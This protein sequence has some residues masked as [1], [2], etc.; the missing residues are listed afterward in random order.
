MKNKKVQ[1]LSLLLFW[2]GVLITSTFA[3]EMRKIFNFS[4]REVNFR[5]ESDYDV[6]M[7][8]GCLLSDEIGK[9]QLPIKPVNFLIPS[10][11]K[12]ED[13]A[14]FAQ[15]IELS[16]EHNILPAQIP[17]IIGQEWQWTEPN[18]EIYTSSN[19]YPQRIVELTNESYLAG[20]KIASILIHPLQ[21]K[22]REKKLILNTEII[23]TLQY[24]QAT[25]TSVCPLR[26]LPETEKIFK[27]MIESIVVNPNDIARFSPRVE[28]VEPSIPQKFAPTEGPSPTSSVV[29]YVIITS[30]ELANTFQN[31]ADWKT[32]KGVPAVVRTLS[33]IRSR[34]DG[35]DD[36]ERIRN[37]IKDAYENWG[38]AWVLIGG[39][40]NVIPYREASMRFYYHDMLRVSTDLYYACLDGNWN[41]DGDDKFGE[42]EDS[43]DLYPEVFVGRASAENIQ[44]AEIFVAKILNYEKRTANTTTDYLTKALFIGEDLFERVTAKDFAIR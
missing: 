5:R 30:D 4:E 31:L 25:N 18:P 19:P 16:G 39:D 37:F 2:L 17:K 26:M 15:S 1:T 28:I 33:W 35:Q 8:K 23:I 6:V 27:K 34:Y 20:N 7:I 22:P 21:Y 12:I 3:G 10:D 44:E 32:R 36:Q 38:T 41:A 42:P 43:T 9:P 24:S 13:I 40:V 29:S 11:A 14:V